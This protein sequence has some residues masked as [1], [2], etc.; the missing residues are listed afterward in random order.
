VGFDYVIVGGGSAGCVLANRLSED[1]RCRVLLLEAGGSGRHLFISMPAGA[2]LLEHGRV[3]NW[4]F[5]TVPQ[6]GLGGRTVAYPRG[7]G[8]GGSSAINGMI[9]VR[10]HPSDFD[11]WAAAGGD[12]WAWRDVRPAFETAEAMLGVGSVPVYSPLGEIFLRACEEIGI[13]R[14]QTFNC[15]DPMGAGP[16]HFNIRNGVRMSARRAYLAPVRAR[17]NLTVR[18]RSHVAAVEFDGERAIGVRI[19]GRTNEIVKARREVILCAGA[20]QSPQLL[21]LSGV[22]P[23]DWLGEHGIGCRIALP[24]VGENLQDHA[25]ASVQVEIDV[26]WSLNR[27]ERLDRMLGA[28]LQWLLTRRGPASV[29]GIEGAAFVRS[30]EAVSIPD[31]QFDFLPAMR[32]HDAKRPQVKAG[33]LLH[34]CPL[35]PKSRGS[36]RLQSADPLAAPL[37]DPGFLTDAADARLLARGLEIARD[38]FAAPAFASVNRG[39]LLPG[40]HVATAEELIGYARRRAHTVYHPVGTCR[41][42]NDANAVVDARLRVHGARAL[43]VVDASVMPTLVGGNTNAATTMIAER[44]ARFIVE[45]VA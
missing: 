4:R 39:E 26:R 2:G 11:G 14:A 25:G 31:L 30:S 19:A 7:R 40:T 18:T 16:Y 20:I 32:V 12:G 21:A 22:G 27:F 33:M 13:P 3:A 15:D 41:M 6:R 44:A 24:G 29:L 17:P 43:R 10:G 28:G 34:A 36:V 37:I 45:E 35:R 5:R 38:M 42:G 8:L 9:W 23:P 1:A